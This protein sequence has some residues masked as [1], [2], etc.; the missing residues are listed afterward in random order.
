MPFLSFGIIAVIAISKSVQLIAPYFVQRLVDGLASGDLQ[1]VS[2]GYLFLYYVLPIAGMGL[3]ASIFWRLSGFMGS[4]LNSKIGVSL[5]SLSY[6]KVFDQSY[7]FFSDHFTGS[8]VRNVRSLRDS[9]STLLD[10]LW[11]EV[12]PMTISVFLATWLLSRHD[13]LL[14]AIVFSWAI[15]LFLFNYATS[16]LKL[17]YDNTRAAAFSKVSGTLADTVTNAINVILFTAKKKEE[18]RLWN[19]LNDL[20]NA[21]VKSWQLGEWSMAIQNIMTFVCEFAILAFVIWKWKAGMMT[22]GEIVFVQGV[23]LE[24]FFSTFNMG[25]M[26]RGVYE[27][28]SDAHEIIEIMDLQPEVR[29]LKSAKKI[30]VKKGRIQFQD[31]S[32]QYVKDETRSVLRNIT[33]DIRA[34]EKIA[35]IGSSGAGKSTIT[36]LL[37]RFFDA[38]SGKIL[39]D[40][41]DISKVTQGSLR[42]AIA[43]VPQESVLFHRSL[44]DNILYGNRDATEK[45]V[46]EAA[47]AAHCHAFITALPEGYETLVGERGVKLSGGERQRVAIARAILR[48]API[49]VLDEATSSL[50]SES[51]AMIQDA[52]KHLMEH[53]TV[54][55]IAHRLSTIM[56]MDRIIVMER[57][58]I[59]DEG[60][61]LSLSN[62]VGTYQK[63]WN[64]QAGGFKV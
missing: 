29:D 13:I 25:R 62:K 64:I 39:I 47:K 18:S 48:D 4:V 34:K 2:L 31:V 21:I 36:K 14:G 17:P 52:L 15:L 55:A 63:L 46:L 40:G 27:A 5:L 20:K 44:M 32:F 19:E 54:I 49:L 50:D 35:L 24:V 56:E 45:Q 33:L 37:F 26:I 28:A 61:H 41:Q 11:W 59:I 7:R 30:Q 16:I 1:N 43:F 8:L 9:G 12:I 23:M 58:H 22:V 3:L 6:R 51:E 38:N 53:K 10:A 57:G 42:D 60:T